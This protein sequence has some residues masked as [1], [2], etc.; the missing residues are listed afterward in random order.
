M[1]INTSMSNNSL[2]QALASSAII[3]SG[4][5]S[6]NS[7][8]SGNSV[9]NSSALLFSSGLS[10]MSSPNNSIVPSSSTT[11][12]NTS[13][14]NSNNSTISNTNNV[15]NNNTNSNS[16]TTATGEDITITIYPIGIKTYGCLPPFLMRKHTLFKRLFVHV[17]NRF[18]IDENELLFFFQDKLLP[19]QCPSDIGLGNGDII[20]V[21]RV[22]PKPK[23]ANE[24]KQASSLVLEIG[25]LY[26]NP[27]FSDISFILDDGSTL[28]AHKNILSARCDKFKAMFQGSMRESTENE[29]KVN[30]HSSIV[31]KKM[32][33]YLYTDTLAEEGG[34]DMVLKLIVIADE[35]LL[36]S[37]K[38]LCEQKLITEINIGNAPLLFSHSDTYSC[39]L[40]KKHCLSFI[41]TSIKKLA[42]SE[43]F[44]RALF[45]FP[46]LLL[47][48]I[49]EMAPSF[50]NTPNNTK[51][52][53]DFE[54]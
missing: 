31:F 44:D 4:T 17:S 23:I 43:E 32:V 3:N 39:A 45:Q 49:K 10:A 13:Q 22:P 54:I 26:D 15:S 38:N 30:E 25:S 35:Y 14:N 9:I 28:Y 41:L 8:S 1:S 50:D 5:T 33:E 53:K 12:S 16:N 18:C 2:H 51:R 34:I 29:I 11:S 37:L 47:E 6:S 36:H 42:A 27:S 40:L 19:E 48:I 52:R 7:N 46:N 21:R 24:S 20:V